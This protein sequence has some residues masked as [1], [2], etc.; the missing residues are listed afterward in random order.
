MVKTHVV[1]VGSL[2]GALTFM[3]ETLT[4]AA[5]DMVQFQFAPKNHTVTQSTFDQPCQPASLNSNITGIYSGFIPV[6]ADASMTATWTV[7]LNDTKPLWLYCS[8]GKHCQSGMVMV[9]NPYV[10]HPQ[11]TVETPLLTP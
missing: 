7:A 4:A 3:P 8:Q 10:T 1:R 6:A 11:M 2:S 9:I 5:G